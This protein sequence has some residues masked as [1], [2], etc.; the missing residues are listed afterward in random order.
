[1]DN[2]D[3]GRFGEQ[4]AAAFLMSEGYRILSFNYQCRLGEIDIIAKNSEF[5][6]FC[7]VKLRKDDTFG[8]AMEF[9]T[10]AKQKRIIKTAFYYL[11][12]NLNAATSILQPRFDVIEIYAPIGEKGEIQIYHCEDAFQCDFTL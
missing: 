4:K 5:I 2:K 3:L 8:S 10:K 9:V 11:Q 7:E 1:M 6:I 12:H